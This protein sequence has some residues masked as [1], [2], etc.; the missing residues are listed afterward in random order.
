MDSA[1]M[2]LNLPTAVCMLLCFRFLTKTKLVTYQ[3]FSSC[4]KAFAKHQG[5][6]SVT[7]PPVIRLGVCKRLG[8]NRTMQMTRV[9]K[10]DIPCQIISFL[11]V[12]C[13]RD[14]LG[15]LAIFHMGTGWVSASWL[16]SGRW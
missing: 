3:C 16:I 15:S 4:R 12:K 6:L 8:G 11:V 7:L 10:R 2:E 1:G 9:T 13:R 14:C 5:H